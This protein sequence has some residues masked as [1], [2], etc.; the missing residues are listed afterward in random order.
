MPPDW[1]SIFGRPGE[2]GNMSSMAWTIETVAAVAVMLA[3]IL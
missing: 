1:H 2:I 3:M